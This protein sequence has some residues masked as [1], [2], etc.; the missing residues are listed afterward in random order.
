MRKIQNSQ[1]KKHK[2]IKILIIIF[3]LLFIFYWISIYISTS[4]ALVP[5]FMNKLEAFK[6][7]TEKSLSEQV[8]SDDIKS[9]R[10]ESI[11][12]TRKWLENVK[13]SK[14]TME[15]EDG[16]TLVAEEFVSSEVTDKW[17]VLLHGYTGWKEEMYP[18]AYWY[19][20]Q[21]YNIL[22][23]DLRCQGESEGDFIGM[24]YTDSFD[25]MKWLDYIIQKNKN[26]KIILHGQSMG[27]S[28]ALIMSG[29]TQL[30]DNVAA[31]ISDCAYTSAYTMF[32]DKVEEWFNIPSN[33]VLEPFCFMLKLR[34]GYDLKKA[35]PI[36]AVKNSKVPILF[37]HGD[38]D[39][40]ISVEHSQSLYE[41]CASKKELLIIEGAGHAQAQDKAPEKYYNKIL[42]FIN[43]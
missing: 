22:V 33:I 36:E 21:G 9:T 8:Q 18:F 2:I 34:G 39:K 6:R 5:D 35:S 14:Q 1:T 32:S 41:A 23:P 27:A 31:V 42:E 26:A 40:L 15:S 30:P 38:M 4:A 43:K 11:S 19:Y 20:Q 12:D 7:I 28:T 3:L 17:V 29:N 10:S 24:G 25:V 16:Y 13:K 37:I